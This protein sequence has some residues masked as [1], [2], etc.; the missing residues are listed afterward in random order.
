LQALADSGVGRQ[1]VY[2]GIDFNHRLVNPFHA[3][4]YT[5]G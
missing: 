2:L 3:T 5:A 4:G 1:L